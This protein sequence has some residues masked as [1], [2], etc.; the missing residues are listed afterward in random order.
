MANF[1]SLS[2]EPFW[3]AHR[4]T[5][6]ALAGN[7]RLRL[8]AVRA[9]PR[10]AGAVAVGLARRARCTGRPRRAAPAG[11]PAPDRTTI[12]FQAA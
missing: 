10:A 1:K 12:V 8:R 6:D 3:R 4:Q 7:R 11:Q 2:L 5:P 9:Q